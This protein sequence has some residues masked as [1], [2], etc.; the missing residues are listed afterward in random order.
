MNTQRKHIIGNEITLYSLT[1]TSEPIFVESIA[2]LKTINN[3]GEVI[4]VHDWKINE[5]GDKVTM[6][7]SFNESLNALIMDAE[8]PC[9]I[10]E[11]RLKAPGRSFSW[12]SFY[13]E[14]RNKKTGETR[15]P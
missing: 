9:F 13:G 14:W 15:K 8:L 10:R 7:Y 1:L 5:A 3:D 12:D 4:F 2:A 11:T 6:R